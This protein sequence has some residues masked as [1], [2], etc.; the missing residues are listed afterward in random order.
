MRRAAL[1]L[2]LAALP[3][4]AIASGPSVVLLDWR[5]GAFAAGG[6][7]PVEGVNAATFDAAVDGCH[8]DLRLDLLY[9]P[10]ETALAAEGVGEAALLHTFRAQLL[11]DGAVLR[12]VSVSRPGYGHPL[13]VAPAGDLQLRLV[14][15]QGAAVSWEMRLRA[16]HLPA[17][18]ACYPDVV[19]AE[20]EANPAG[21]DADA[22][23]VELWNREAA[24]VDVGG[25]SVAGARGEV[26]LPE[27]TLLPPDGRLVVALPGDA[28]DDVDGVVELRILGVV[29]DATPPLTDAAD[30]GRTWH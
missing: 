28:L 29:R 13:G 2:L 11:S 22:E 14:L 19:V 25:W 6:P 3:L 17:E 4:P 26:V 12:T 23:W 9:A 1:L 30:D 8:R 18:P 10:E 15:A 5:A 21:P 27:G 20:V 7:V 16:W 24:T